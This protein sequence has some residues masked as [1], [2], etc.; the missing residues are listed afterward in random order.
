VKERGI[1]DRVEA[2]VIA[3]KRADV[4][5][6]ETGVGQSALGGLSA[7]EFDRGRRHV[8]PDGDET[9][10]YW[11]PFYYLLEDLPGVELMLVNAR[12]VKNLLTPLVGFGLDIV[13]E[14]RRWC[15]WRTMAAGVARCGCL[16]SC[17]GWLVRAA[18]LRPPGGHALA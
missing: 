16:H 14:Y 2:L 15:L 18:G 4:G 1:D 11:K 17:R 12:H 13:T 5:H 8:Q 6:L 3:A 7:G 9:G 10:D